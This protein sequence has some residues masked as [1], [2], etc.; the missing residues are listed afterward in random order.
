MI[1]KKTCQ[2]EVIQSP[3]VKAARAIFSGIGAD[4]V[5]GI[6]RDLDGR[7][8]LS[9]RAAIM[10]LGW[11]VFVESSQCEA[12]FA[13]RR[14]A[15]AHGDITACECRPFGDRAGVRATGNLICLDEL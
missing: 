1:H 8:A 12:F 15:R 6:T 11:L 5:E 3:R 13:T 9:A 4:D 7:E 10:P 14:V 2:S